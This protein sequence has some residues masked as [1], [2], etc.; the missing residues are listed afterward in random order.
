MQNAQE[1]PPKKSGRSFTGPHG[2]IAQHTPWNSGFLVLHED[3]R[4]TLELWRLYENWAQLRITDDE[5]ADD[6]VGS[7][8]GEFQSDGSRKPS[9]KS[10]S[11]DTPIH[12]LN[13]TRVKYEGTFSERLA[14]G[15]KLSGL[16]HSG[17]NQ[18]F[19]EDTSKL[20]GGKPS[21]WSTDGKFFLYY[22]EEYAHWKA[23]G[24]RVVGGDGVVAVQPGR[25]RAGHGF[26]HS[27]PGDSFDAL[28]CSKGW[29]EDVQN[30]WTP[31]DVSIMPSEALALEFH[32]SE[33][34]ATD[35]EVRG[36]ETMKESFVG[37]SVTFRGSCSSSVSGEIRL[38]LPSPPE[39]LQEGSVEIAPLS[40]IAVGTLA[41]EKEGGFM[42]DPQVFLM[43]RAKDGR[44]RL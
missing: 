7:R 3:H 28:R 41:P 18:L 16:R 40:A 22:A 35:K 21:W 38:M 17:L 2:D 36:D 43:K 34:M 10:S 5:A 31:V 23:N 11:S 19:V 25:R 33:V 4:F 29:F 20:I 9:T 24:L 14:K 37:G 39:R 44:A 6:E 42:G 30:V 32:A 13:D 8:S 27:G 26:A 1:L 12:I 15:V